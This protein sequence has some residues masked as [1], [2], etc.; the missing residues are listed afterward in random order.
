MKAE[1]DQ[2]QKTRAQIHDAGL[3]KRPVDLPPVGVGKFDLADTVNAA[4]FAEELK[5]TKRIPWYVID[6]DGDNI[7]RQRL[8]DRKEKM[9]RREASTMDT[10]G[11]GLISAE[12]LARATSIVGFV[13]GRA[14]VKMDALRWLPCFH[15]GATRVLLRLNTRA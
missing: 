3:L 9:L 11:D 13:S 8:R 14:N 1:L 7:R 12:E 15:K 10:G 4:T 6:P 5:H 2:Q